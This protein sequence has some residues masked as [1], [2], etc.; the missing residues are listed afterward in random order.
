MPLT[1]S[2]AILCEIG[3][4]AVYQSHI[5]AQMANFIQNL[6]YL[7]EPRGNLITHRLS[8]G[9][10]I[11]LLGSLLSHEFGSNHQ[12]F[13]RFE[14]FR[15]KVVRLE[16]QRNKFVHSMWAFGST[17]KPDSATRIKVVKNRTKGAQL[18]STQV[19]LKDLEEVSAAMEQLEWEIGDL[20]VRV[21]YHEASARQIR[22]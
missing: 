3:R 18:E 16:E 20:R 2:D 4:I 13:E 21:C 15:K 19:A 7:D 1:V 6:L 14:E 8:F 12:H 22:I 10:L 9:A 5:E 11:D 17:L